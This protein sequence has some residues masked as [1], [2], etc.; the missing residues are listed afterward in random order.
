MNRVQRS[1]QKQ[2]RRRDEV[3]L[4]A[5]SS[6]SLSRQQ[7]EPAQHATQMSEAAV[8]G[9]ELAALRATVEQMK[10][11]R[12]QDLEQTEQQR[13]QDLEQMKQQR[14]QDL[15]QTKQQRQQDLEQMEQQRQQDLEQMEQQR[16][17]SQQA[18]IHLEHCLEQGQTQTQQLLQQMM[19][20]LQPQQQA[21]DLGDNTQDSAASRHDSRQDHHSAPQA[22]ATCRTGRGDDNPSSGSDSSDDDS[23]S[24]GSDRR[25]GNR[26]SRRSLL[27]RRR[28]DSD[29]GPEIAP[30]TGNQATRNEWAIKPHPPTTYSGAK[31]GIHAFIHS[32]NC[33]LEWNPS[34]TA[35][36]QVVFAS[37]FLTG[38]AR[39]WL[40][41]EEARDRSRT[42]GLANWQN[43]RRVM[44]EYFAPTQIAAAVRQTL[45][46]MQQTRS[47]ADY[48]S[49]FNEELM[50]LEVGP[51]VETAMSWFRRGLK[52]DVGLQLATKKFDTLEDMQTAAME[53]DDALQVYARRKKQYPNARASSGRLNQTEVDD[54]T[55]SDADEI[56]VSVAKVSAP[57][58]KADSFTEQLSK[59]QQQLNT[60][61]SKGKS[62]SKSKPKRTG[63]NPNWSA[64]K[65][66]Q[67]ERNECFGCGR[68]GH[69][70]RFCPS[71]LSSSTLK[72]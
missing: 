57:K 11:Q 51:D 38:A 18:L 17:Q 65:K 67:Y 48:A 30:A 15:E 68:Q 50:K 8:P 70:V 9:A 20:R 32:I 29:D 21:P 36:Q 31:N 60:L 6:Q 1:P 28:R 2:Q 56:E 55:Q 12:Q 43:M 66:A 52:E 33:A 3:D 16:Q 26:R 49:R 27:P 10:Q 23:R 4:S 35:R 46:S 45:E 39:T 58:L 13:Q 59:M 47:A 72:D 71:R 64:S 42:R 40:A 54:E 19:A 41:A 34:L 25:R 69:A 37:S 5:N 24:S 22:S 61:S 53:V 63:P 62:K 44:L 14:Q 7:S